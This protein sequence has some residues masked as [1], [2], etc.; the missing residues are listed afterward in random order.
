MSHHP[1]S[2]HESS[3]DDS[4]IDPHEVR[5]TSRNNI[6]SNSGLKYNRNNDSSILNS[7]VD[8]DDIQ[9]WKYR[10]ETYEKLKVESTNFIVKPFLIGMSVAIGMSFGY[11]VYDFVVGIFSR[12]RTQQ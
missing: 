2:Q 4:E 5:R 3:F 6:S 9:V 11:G 1:T 12:R 10:K 7:S 8:E